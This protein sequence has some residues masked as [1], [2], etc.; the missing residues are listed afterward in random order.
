MTIDLKVL[1]SS[2]SGN[3]GLI[4]HHGI[5]YLIDAG[6]SGKKINEKLAQF[7]ISLEDLSGVFITHEH[8]DHIKGFKKLS[9]L[10]HLKFYAN[11]NT[12]QIIED[13]LQL[14]ARWT[15]FETDKIFKV[16]TLSVLGFS[17]PHDAKDP[18]GYLFKSENDSCIWATDIGHITP[19]ISQLLSKTRKLVLESNHELQLL[20]QH[21][22]RP[23]YLKE[24]IAGPYGHL[25]NQDVFN[26]IKNTSHNWQSICLAHISKD[27]NSV[28]LLQNLFQPLA[29]E[30]QFELEIIDPVFDS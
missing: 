2:S 21:P 11:Y 8:Q 26:F 1:G 9:K 12:A 20:W 22:T 6:F 23:Q 10:K 29:E 19:K 18:V 4:V 5:Y 30:Q 13:R 3:C 24:R 16:N 25:S 7:G 17:I 15:I 14:N 27:C 28:Q